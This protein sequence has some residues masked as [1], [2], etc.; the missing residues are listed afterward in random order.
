MIRQTYLRAALG[1]TLC[2]AIA[3]GCQESDSPLMPGT[4]RIETRATAADGSEVALSGYHL[5][6]VTNS[7]ITHSDNFRPGNAINTTDVKS[8]TLA[9]T[10][11]KVTLTFPDKDITTS[12]LIKYEGLDSDRYPLPA[13]FL[14]KAD[15]EN[16]T[17]L[18]LPL[19]CQTATLR[20]RVTGDLTL[21]SVLNFTLQDMPEGIKLDGTLATEKRSLFIP[22][23]KDSDTTA[24]TATINCFPVDDAK[25]MYNQSEDQ[26]G[27]FSLGK[28]EAG[29]SYTAD[30]TLWN[31][32]IR[33]NNV[34]VKDWDNGDQIGDGEAEI[35]NT[36]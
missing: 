9:A 26:T 5:Y 10:R 27:T 31:N 2:A 8:I 33:V 4:V 19:T 28:L 12:S 24:F 34:T 23:T 36:I 30:L 32:T 29:K 25:F 6:C 14:G 18:V 22:L 15:V 1:L 3:T 21:A 20:F 7:S 11:G 13:L 16:A 35:P 17:Y